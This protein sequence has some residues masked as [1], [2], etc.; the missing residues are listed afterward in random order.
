MDFNFQ[1]IFTSLISIGTLY[2][3]R[4]WGLHDRKIEHDKKVLK[5]ILE[6]LPSNGSIQFIRE[7]DFGGSFHI[8]KLYDI[9]NFVS[10]SKRPEYTF[11]NKDVEENRLSLLTSINKFS[12]FVGLNTFPINKGEP[13]VNKIIPSHFLDDP[14]DYHQVHNEIN[15]LA[16]NVSC[17]F[18]NLISSANKKG[19]Y[20]L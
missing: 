2:L 6:V 4:L 16:D 10:I 18:D 7:F 17:C 20:S 5:K 15:K 8:E 3:G 19:I 14:N 11:L 9:D 1:W 12:S 13:W